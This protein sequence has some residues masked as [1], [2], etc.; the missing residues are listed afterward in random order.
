MLQRVRGVV[1]SERQVLVQQAG[2]NSDRNA[3]C[4]RQAHGHEHVCRRFLALQPGILAEEH[5]I[6]KLETGVQERPGR[7]ER[8]CEEDPHQVLLARGRDNH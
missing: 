1:C 7:G 2:K 8:Q 5:V 6:G 4:R 3:G